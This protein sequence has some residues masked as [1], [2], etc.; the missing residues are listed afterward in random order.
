[1]LMLFD[2]TNTQRK[3][4][5]KYTTRKHIHT[6]CRVARSNCNTYTTTTTNDDEGGGGVLV[7]SVC[8]I[9]PPNR[10][11]SKCPV[12]AYATILTICIIPTLRIELRVSDIDCE[13]ATHVSGWAVFVCFAAAQGAAGILCTPLDNIGAHTHKTLPLKSTNPTAA[14]SRTARTAHPHTHTHTYTNVYT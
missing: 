10:V 6:I 11:P 4:S 14:S 13:C 8:K 9:V 1:M 12:C 7:Q 5:N 2:D 3:Y